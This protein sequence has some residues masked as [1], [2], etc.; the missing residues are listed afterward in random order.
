MDEAPTLVEYVD[1]HSWQYCY[2]PFDAME[3]E[4]NMVFLDQR[5][6]SIGGPTEIKVLD[7]INDWFLIGTELTLL[8]S[9]ASAGL[10]CP[11]VTRSTFCRKSIMSGAILYDQ[12]LATALI[13]CLLRRAAK[14]LVYVDL[15]VTS[16]QTT[17]QR[18]DAR[19]TYNTL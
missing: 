15:D 2:L 6:L 7:W 11:K 12:S 1:V 9:A 18:P 19:L 5:V 17:C 10:K 8:I 4:L 14:T 16:L 13:W 3:T